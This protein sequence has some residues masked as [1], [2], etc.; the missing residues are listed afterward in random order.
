MPYKIFTPNQVTAAEVNTYLMQQ[1]VSTFADAT[2]R[3]TQLTSPLEGQV[4]YLQDVKK[5]Q[6]WNGSSWIA[7]GAGASSTYTLMEIGP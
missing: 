1:A 6:Y 2:A 4:T 3:S 7:V 5:L